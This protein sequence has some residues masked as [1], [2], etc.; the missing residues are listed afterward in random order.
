MSQIKTA[1]TE[2]AKIS[3]NEGPNHLFLT[4]MTIL[5]KMVGMST[6]VASETVLTYSK[7]FLKTVDLVVFDIDNRTRSIDFIEKI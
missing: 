7:Q 5:L 1:K 3:D 6:I 2:S 4:P